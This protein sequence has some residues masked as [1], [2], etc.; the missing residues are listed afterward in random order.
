MIRGK[1]FIECGLGAYT[2]TRYMR[3]TH[4]ILLFVGSV[5]L[6]ESTPFHPPDIQVY[7]VVDRTAYEYMK[8]LEKSV[9]PQVN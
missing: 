3:H 7:W 4:S 9:V 6:M 1:D 5:P 8:P 2:T